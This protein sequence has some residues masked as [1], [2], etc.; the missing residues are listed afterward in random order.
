MTLEEAKAN[1]GK[2]VVYTGPNGKEETG[3][4]NGNLGPSHLLIAVLFD[5]WNR[6]GGRREFVW[7]AQ[8]RFA[9]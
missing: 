7:P 1:I 9:E 6:E 4:L 5:D 2:K 8:L 3:R